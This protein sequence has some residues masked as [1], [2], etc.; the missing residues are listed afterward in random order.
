MDREAEA[1]SFIVRRSA[2]FVTCDV[3]IQLIFRRKFFKREVSDTPRG[4][5]QDTLIWHNILQ[6]FLVKSCRIKSKAIAELLGDFSKFFIS[7]EA[8]YSVRIEDVFG[9]AQDIYC[10]SSC[11]YRF[12][13][14]E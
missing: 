4:L 13:E 1:Y 11:R 3:V 14:P 6:I 7:D 12:L 2:D 9:E 5:R 10:G 8:R